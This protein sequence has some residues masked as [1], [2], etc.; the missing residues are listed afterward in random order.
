VIERPN[1]K[2]HGLPCRY[3]GIF[4]T[5]LGEYSSRRLRNGIPVPRPVR[6]QEDTAVLVARNT[7]DGSTCYS[8]LSTCKL[9]HWWFLPVGGALAPSTLKG[10]ATFEPFLLELYMR[11]RTRHA[12]PL[13]LRG[14]HPNTSDRRSQRRNQRQSTPSANCK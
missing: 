11:R 14:R 2:P 1:A 4:R 3:E 9:S 13:V 6:R 7:N 5:A 12:G 8:L 10:L